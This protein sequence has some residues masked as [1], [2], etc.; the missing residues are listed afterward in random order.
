MHR[1]DNGELKQLQMMV[2]LIKTYNQAM[3]VEDTI[4]KTFHVEKIM[5]K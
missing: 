1:T 3:D 5:M 4:E 2:N